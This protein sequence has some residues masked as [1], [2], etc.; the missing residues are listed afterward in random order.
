MGKTRLGLQ[1][2]AQQIDTYKHGVYFVPLA[3][4]SS[5]DAIVSALA[6]ALKYSFSGSDEP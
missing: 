2:V 1:T 5:A 3:P 4:L 6:D